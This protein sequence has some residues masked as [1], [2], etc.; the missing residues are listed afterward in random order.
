MLHACN[1]SSHLSAAPY[2]ALLCSAP[3][4]GFKNLPSGDVGTNGWSIT[5]AQK[6]KM[7]KAKLV[8]TGTYTFYREEQ[9]LIVGAEQVGASIPPGTADQ[10]L[11]NCLNACDNEVWCAGITIKMN[12]E[13]KDRPTTCML[14]K[15]AIKLGVFKRTVVR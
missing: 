3:L 9:A 13:L 6:K 15:G 2:N 8:A 7:N 5:D 12:V 10:D 14:I 4:I 1:W 11:Q